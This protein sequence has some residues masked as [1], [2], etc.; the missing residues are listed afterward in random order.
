MQ[1][2]F[3]PVEI[4]EVENLNFEVLPLHADNAKHYYK[5]LKIAYIDHYNYF[6]VAYLDMA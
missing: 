6:Q 1:I 5:M 4:V 3:I 2:F